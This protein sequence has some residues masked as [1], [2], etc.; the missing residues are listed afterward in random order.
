MPCAG[1]WDRTPP[2]SHCLYPFSIHLFS[3]VYT[4]RTFTHTNS[5]SQQKAIDLLGTSGWQSVGSHLPYLLSTKQTLR[6]FVEQ[7]DQFTSLLIFKLH[8]PKSQGRIQNERKTESIATKRFE[9]FKCSVCLKIIT[10]LCL[11][12]HFPSLFLYFTCLSFSLIPLIPLSFLL[13]ISLVG[14]C[15]QQFS[16]GSSFW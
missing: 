15:W 1:L 5:E 7:R 10:K 2:N 8:C 16:P 9:Y 11:P 14:R 6:G 13:C 4:A 3:L 12:V